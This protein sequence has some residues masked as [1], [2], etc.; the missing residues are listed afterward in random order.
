M[1]ATHTLM[2]SHV[3]RFFTRMG[4]L[5]AAGLMSATAFGAATAKPGAR[6]LTLEIAN[7]IKVLTEAAALAPHIMLESRAVNPAGVAPAAQTD[8][9]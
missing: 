1:N 9:E 5:C 4:A 2:K 6:E 3:F 7:H 8:H